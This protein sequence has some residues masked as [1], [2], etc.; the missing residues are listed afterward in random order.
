VSHVLYARYSDL[1][2]GD[3]VSI[4]AGSEDADYPKEQ[5]ADLDRNYLSLKVAKFTGTSGTFR[6]TFGG[7]QSPRAA[8]FINTTATAITLSNGAGLSEAITIPSTPEDSLRLDPW[9]DLAGK[10]NL[11]STQWNAALT[12]AAGVGLGEFV[13]AAQLRELLALW[14]PQPIEAESHPGFHYETDGEVDL[15]YGKALRVRRG[16]LTARDEDGRAALLALHRAQQG[17]LYPFLLI[18]NAHV[19]DAMLVKFDSDELQLATVGGSP[20]TANQFVVDVAFRV[21]EVQKGIL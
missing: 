10:A 8:V 6:R 2:A 21:K 13:L 18:P 9:I 17:R 12:G 4:V 3:T 5:V 7:N 11:A 20:T 1:L 14:Q 16:Y 19:N 15:D